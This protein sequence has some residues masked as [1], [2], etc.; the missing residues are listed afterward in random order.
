MKYLLLGGSGFIGSHLA[1]LLISEGQEVVI[2]DRKQLDFTKCNDFTKYIEDVDVIVHMVSTIIPSE[3]ISRIDLEISDNVDPTLVLCRD[4]SRLNKKII[5]VSSGGVVYGENNKKNR[6][7]SPTNPICNYGIIKLM[8][9]K[10]LALYHDYCGLEYRIVRPS[11]PY[12]EKVYHNKK[13]GVVPVII[14]SM[15]ED[16]PIMV[17]GDGQIRDYIYIDDLVD[18]INAVLKYDGPE[19]IFN[20]GSGVGHTINDIIKMAE[21]R[22]KKRAKIKKIPVRKCDVMKNVLDISLIERETGWRPKISLEDGVEK[23]IKDLYV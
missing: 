7:I 4:A 16:K 19:R 6:E 9:E 1:K 17:Y 5:F 23:I 11:N 13:Q 10:Y 14:D 3:D 21:G 20:I 2:I 22:M 12:S 15:K 8:I 18:G